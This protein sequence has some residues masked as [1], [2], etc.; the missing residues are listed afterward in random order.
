G[1]ARSYAHIHRW[2]KEQGTATKEQTKGF[3]R[4]TRSIMVKSFLKAGQPTNAV[5]TFLGRGPFAQP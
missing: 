4:K 3:R 1:L 5:L 2:L